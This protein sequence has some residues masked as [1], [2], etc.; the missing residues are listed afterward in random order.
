MSA[1]NAN[2]N[3]QQNKKHD[4]KAAGQIIQRICKIV[5]AQD[6]QTKG[7]RHGDHGDPMPAGRSLRPTLEDKQ[8]HE[9]EKGTNPDQI[10]GGSIRYSK[11]KTERGC[12][13]DTQMMDKMHR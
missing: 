7:Q 11:I 1:Y 6:R 8:K 3:T 5:G 4:V 10:N 9:I 2:Q 13:K 12:E